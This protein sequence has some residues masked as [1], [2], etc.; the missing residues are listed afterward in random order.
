MKSSPTRLA[1]AKS[2]VELAGNFKPTG[3]RVAHAVSAIGPKRTLLVA[4]H[5]SA[6]RGEADIGTSLG[7]LGL[8]GWR[9]KRESLGG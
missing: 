6:F 3:D 2:G 9:R 7:V 8:H 5:M 4:L 1:T